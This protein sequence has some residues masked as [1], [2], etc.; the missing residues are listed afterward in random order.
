MGIVDNQCALTNHL[1]SL[2][3]FTASR[4]AA[5][6]LPSVERESLGMHRTV[7]GVKSVCK[8]PELFTRSALA[9]RGLT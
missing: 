7:L 8:E 5:V 4:F 9:I 2:L 1:M 6:A 3:L